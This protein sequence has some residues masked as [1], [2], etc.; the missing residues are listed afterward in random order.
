MELTVFA[1]TKEII[2]I[3]SFCYDNQGQCWKREHPIAELEPGVD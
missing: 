3:A 1:F 2:I